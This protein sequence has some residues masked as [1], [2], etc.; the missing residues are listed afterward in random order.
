MKSFVVF[1][2]SKQRRVLVV[3]AIDL[4]IQMVSLGHELSG[5]DMH[6]SRS[7]SAG[8]CWNGGGMR[9]LR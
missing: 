9:S 2:A 7:Q 3:L 8:S 1:A 5:F 6:L 4:L